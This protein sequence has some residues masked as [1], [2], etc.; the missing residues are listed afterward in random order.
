MKFPPTRE[1]NIETVRRWLSTNTKWQDF[2]TSEERERRRAL[3]LH[4]L[5]YIPFCLLRK[6]EQ[7]DVLAGRCELHMHE[8]T[9]I[10]D[11][12]GVLK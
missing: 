8:H 11:Y 7:D 6:N 5:R 4:E 1:Q 2:E 3:L 12:A 9:P 10:L